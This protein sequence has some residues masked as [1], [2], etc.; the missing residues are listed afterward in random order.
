MPRLR[1]LA[2]LLLA[3]LPLAARAGGIPFGPNVQVTDAGLGRLNDATAP[4]LAAQGGALY[5]TWHDTRGGSSTQQSIFF[6]RSDDGGASW[7]PNVMASLP[8]YVGFTDRPAISVAPDGSIWIAWWLGLCISTEPDE[9]GGEDLQN[10]T[11]LAV[12]TDG[13]RTFEEFEAFDGRNTG[14]YIDAFPEIA[15]ENDRTLILTVNPAGA[16]A[17]VIVRTARRTAP[18]RVA[19]TTV[20]VSTPGGN[21]RVT[22]GV[23]PDGPLLSMA[24]R[25]DVVCA[26]WEDTRQR[27]A[28][29]GACSADRGASFGPNFQISGSDD[30]NPRLAFAPDG[31]LYATYQDVQ[32]GPLLVRRSADNGASWDAPN[33]AF[34]FDTGDLK[35][36]SYDL[37]VDPAGQVLITA[38][39]ATGS[40]W[41]SQSNLY[42][43]TSVDRGQR[44]ALTGPLEDGQGEYPTV[45]TQSN[46]RTAI[47]QGPGGPRAFV[48]WSDD[49]NTQDQIW[50]AR[51]DLDGTPPT[52]PTGLI[53][54]PGDTTVALSWGAAS[55][56]S[57]IAGYH[58]LRAASEAG[59]FQQITPRLVTA[60]SY[61]D[62]GLDGATYFYRV[63]AVDGTGN[64]GPPSNTASAAASAGTGLA[65][66]RGTIA[67]DLGGSIALRAID[68]ALGEQRVIGEGAQP[69]FSL[70][71]AEVLATIG[72]NGNGAV[73]G[74]R[75]DGGAA[76]TVFSTD[77]LI[78]GVDPTAD[79]SRIAV[80]AR[81]FYYPPGGFCQAF[82]PRLIDVRSGQSPLFEESSAIASDLSISGDG[83]LLAYTYR[84]WCNAAA[85]GVYD[86]PRLCITNTAT[87]QETCLDG[88]NVDAS[89]F[90]PGR[91]RIV[92]AA[93]FTGQRELWRADVQA[94]G[95]L[96]NLVQLTRGPAG[97]PSTA[98]QVSTDGNWVIFERDLDPGQGENPVLHVVRL[99]G[100]GLRSLGVQGAAPAW[101]GGGSA[102]QSGPAGSN[103]AYLPLV[104][105]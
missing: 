45:S 49:R 50:S 19:F 88:A 30:F 34:P 89:D 65:G 86:T 71:G 97:Q 69:A 44:F 40:G 61:R 64:P 92:F 12:S 13:G 57:G 76:R 38:A 28:I 79:P 94:N 72:A 29:F 7:G 87:K 14:D 52:A 98:P 60:T 63:F 77:T 83:A 32:G 55:D 84:A 81:Q 24:T 42:L 26:A 25:G 10:D 104:R 51:V 17:D 33:V 70:D 74:R 31:T 48:V 21:G 22:D 23:I 99:D 90:V 11:S 16:G 8:E 6:A 15:A 66:L 105:R 95:A 2:A 68:G 82:E 3:L 54:Q 18:G 56:Q 39:L 43:A 103:R 47:G 41:S 1:L 4:E 5:A 36:G 73:V 62:V 58:V 53:A 37:D 67:Y 75:L 102:P 80:I 27:F 46:P 93:D 20:P 100:E 35:I 101:S 78:A 96:A 59:P 9:C 85:S 91:A